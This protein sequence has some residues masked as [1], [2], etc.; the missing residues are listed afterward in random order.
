M[1]RTVFAEILL[2]ISYRSENIFVRDYQ[3]NYV[4]A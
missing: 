3:K 2:I 1:E 4:K